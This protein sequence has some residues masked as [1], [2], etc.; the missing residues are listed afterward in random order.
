MNRA[1]LAQNHKHWYSRAEYTAEPAEATAVKQKKIFLF[2]NPCDET[3]VLSKASFKAMNE[4]NHDDLLEMKQEN[5][6]AIITKMLENEYIDE[7]VPDE[8]DDEDGPTLNR[9][10][11][12][13]T[14]KDSTDGPTSTCKEFLDELRRQL[15]LKRNFCSRRRA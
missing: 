5:R 13:K 10:W 9:K 6:N 14:V 4:M 3:M 11:G 7:L 15:S 2:R 1:S 8:P 12:T